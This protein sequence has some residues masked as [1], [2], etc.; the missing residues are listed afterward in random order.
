MSASS[1]LPLVAVPACRKIDILPGHWVTEK[2]LAAVADGAGAMPVIVPAMAGVSDS[3]ARLDELM[4]RVDGLLLTGSPSNVEPHRYGGPP[5][6]DGTAHDAARDATTLPMIRAALEAG[7]PIFAICRGVQE[8][9]VAMGG[10]L[11]QLVHELEGRIDHR[12][13]KSVPHEERY[14]LRH[15]VRLREGGK[16]A[17][18]YGG[19]LELMVNSLH[20]QAIDRIARGLTVEAA[21]E[22]GTIEAVSVDDAP[23]FQMGVQ[24]HPEWRFWEDPMSRAL[25]AA[26]GAA[27]R[28]RAASRDGN[29]TARNRG[30]GGAKDSAACGPSP[31]RVA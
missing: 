2:Y 3:V 7:L 18:L 8:L 28:D 6:R 16:L 15:P 29:S 10:S 26:F 31:A 4:D 27:V 24:W 19:P 12:S 30:H 22:D 21:A 9:N 13:D 20:A 14:D 5:S 17:A 11:H 23:T 25:F 1:H